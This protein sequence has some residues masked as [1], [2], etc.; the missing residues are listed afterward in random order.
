M[1]F[2]D[3]KN[4]VLQVCADGACGVLAYSHLGASLIV[5]E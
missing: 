5:V 4:V 1:T 2:T 3:T